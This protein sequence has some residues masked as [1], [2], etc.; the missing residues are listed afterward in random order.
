MHTARTAVLDVWLHDYH[1]GT[2]T[3]I[4][5]D[6]NIFALD[7]AYRADPNAPILSFKA[8]RDQTGAYRRAFRPTQTR[9]HPFFS[10]LLP[11]GYLRQ[12][13]AR[14]AHVKPVRDFPLIWMLGHDLPG[15]LR[16]VDA[17]GSAVPPAGRDHRGISEDSRGELLRFSLAGV[18]L[19]FS[20]TG[21]PKRGLTIPVSGMGGHWIVKMPDQ[22]FKRVPENEFSMM[23]FAKAVGIDVPDI[24]LIDPGTIA[25]MPSDVRNL[26]GNA[27]Y[28]KRFDRLPSGGRVQTEDF[29]QANGIFPGNDRKYTQFN[30][31]SLA[32]Q[33]TRQ[34]GVSG[35]LDLTRRLVFTVGIGNGDMHSKNWSFI[36]RDGR[37]AELAPAYDFVSTIVYMPDDDLGMNLLGSK[38]FDDFDESR[39]RA[40]ADRA[41]APRKPVLDTA[42]EM[43]NRMREQWPRT[44]SEIPMEKADRDF[45]TKHM[46]RIPLFR[47]RAVG[48]GLP[49]AKKVI[50]R[51]RRSVQQLNEK[52]RSRNSQ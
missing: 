36:Y 49:A 26:T 10:N 38:S 52:E 13:L 5:N 42:Y 18:Q 3:N 31:D 21:D 27:Y 51:S 28:I 43:V 34:A 14:H 32:E 46:D 33:V 7:E 4:V 30:F 41:L 11:E 45:I 39:L 2:I 24:G 48:I 22:R 8:F 6:T 23:S 12:Y 40:L 20:A 1:V 44:A 25:G 15:A 17:D 37:T 16:V 29:A 35:M 9:L 50:G 47:P 19:K